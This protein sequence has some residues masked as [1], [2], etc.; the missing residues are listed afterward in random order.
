MSL[1]LHENIWPYF[2]SFWHLG[3]GQLL[4]MPVQPERENPSE[5]EP[6]L[7]WLPLQILQFK[8]Y[9]YLV[10]LQ[11]LILIDNGEEYSMDVWRGSCTNHLYS[12]VTKLQC[13]KLKETE[14]CHQFSL[15]HL[16][17]VCKCTKFYLWLVSGHRGSALCHK[18]W[19]QIKRQDSKLHGNKK[20][21]SQW[22]LV[23]WN[24]TFSKLVKDCH[25]FVKTWW[26]ECKR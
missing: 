3:K 4:K 8:L 16:H 26:G 13:Q 24:R 25:F 1:I 15:T 9:L 5:N 18:F 22:E 17:P 23:Y 6:K 20:Y 21:F 2:H 14:L 7:M 11:F 10:Y 19:Q 12:F